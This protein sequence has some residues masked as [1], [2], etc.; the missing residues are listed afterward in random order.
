MMQAYSKEVCLVDMNLQAG[1]NLATLVN[2]VWDDDDGD[3]GALKQIQSWCAEAVDIN[4]VQRI[5]RVLH[6]FAEKEDDFSP[7]VLNTMASK[8][9]AVSVFSPVS[10]PSS[11]W[12]TRR[13]L[14]F[15]VSRIVICPIVVYGI[16]SLTGHQHIHRDW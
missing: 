3:S 14:Y 16:Y 7:E 4:T 8:L 11:V 2:R 1:T 12:R 9:D 5:Y 15:F 10:R 6:L 13:C